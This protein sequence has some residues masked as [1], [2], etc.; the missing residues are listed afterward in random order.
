M[1]NL[2]WQILCSIIT[3]AAIWLMGNRWKY[4]PIVGVASAI[5][6]IAYSWIYCLWGLMPLNIFSLVVYIRNSYLWIKGENNV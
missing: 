6:W 2:I 3:I 4:A 5:T 1:T